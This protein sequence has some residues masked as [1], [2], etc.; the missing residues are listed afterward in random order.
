MCLCM[1]IAEVNALLGDKVE[2]L[3]EAT[4]QAKMRLALLI[5]W[6]IEYRDNH[7]D[8]C[9]WL[10]GAST[11]LQRLVARAESTQPPRVSPTELL[12]DIQVL[13]GTQQRRVCNTTQCKVCRG[14]CL[15]FNMRICIVL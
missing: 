9:Q 13:Y 11:R 15:A 8:L 4:E 14:G 2:H 6:W 3:S 10:E 5:Q 12:V 7:D 1:Q